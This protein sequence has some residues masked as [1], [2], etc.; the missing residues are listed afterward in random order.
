MIPA[1]SPRFPGGLGQHWQMI[2]WGRFRGPAVADPLQ[3]RRRAERLLRLVS[4]AVRIEPGF[5][6][7]VRLL[8][9]PEEA[10][11]ATEADVWQHPAVTST[12]IDGATLD[13][14]QA[15]LLR[16]AFA[17]DA[18]QDPQLHRRVLALLR[19]WRGHLPREIWFEEVQSLAPA[20]RRLLPDPSDVAL[21]QRFFLQLSQRARGVAPGTPGAGALSWFRRCERRLTP[22]AWTDPGVG[23][24]LHQ[25]SWSLHEQD[26]GFRPAAGFDPALV[27]ATWE[28][29]LALVQKGAVLCVTEL[30]EPT[31][32]PDGTAS[33]FGLLRS[34]NGL[35][36]LTVA[37]N[38]GR[39]DPNFWEI[40]RAPPWATDWGWDQYAAWV[41]FSINELAAGERVTQRM[42]WIQP[43]SFQMGSAT[44]EPGRWVD[45]GHRHEVGIREG[46]WLFETAC[47]QALWVAVMGKNPARF[48]GARR[49]V[50]RV[51][52]ND[53]Q[54]FI[55]ALNE[56]LPGLALSL[57]S[58][59]RWEYA[60]RAGSTTRYSFGD[61]EG[62]LGEHAWFNENAGGETHPVRE[63]K[64]NAWGLYDMQGNILEWVQDVWSHRYHGAPADG[65]AWESK[66][67][68]AVRVLRGGSWRSE[69]RSCRCAYRVGYQPDSN[70]DDL[71]FRC[72]RVQGREPGSAGSGASTLDTARPAERIRPGGHEIGTRNGSSSFDS[73][74]VLLRLDAGIE[75]SAPLPRAPVIHIRTDREQ[76]TLGGIA[77]PDWAR[78]IG[79]DRFGLWCEIAVETN[80]GEP[81]VQ[82]LRWIPP[83]RFRMGS[84]PDEP[85]HHPVEGPQHLVSLGSG[86]W[87]FDTPCTQSLW[88]ALMGDNPSAFRTPDRPVES[89]GWEEVKGFLDALNHR[90]GE[91]DGRF[92]LPSEA[93]WEYA[94]RAGTTTA[95]YS[96]SIEILGDANAPA[97]DPI[98]WYGGNSGVGFE[99]A[100]GLER[101]WLREMQYPE[102]RAGT[103]PV[104]GKRPNPWGLY[105]MLGN[106]WEWTQDVW[107]DSYEG[108]PSDGAARKRDDASAVRV[109]RGGSWSVNAR[110][111]RCAYRLKDDPD[112]RFNLL[113][114]RCAR[115][116]ES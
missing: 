7:A 104:K 22:S 72:A 47:T 77:K 66:D 29:R 12:S 102:G 73:G 61:D 83:G 5:L 94:C 14:A 24:A 85:G 59:A 6:R 115:T 15:A 23:A 35:V 38:A 98:A 45:E 37:A 57:P 101:T 79:R 46:F 42:R 32:L 110:H 39:K 33:P 71:G 44:Q 74:S 76:F 70:N 69:A 106:V 52:W 99:L 90:L 107:V 31:A 50:E 112:L 95:L 55:A 13:P 96:G 3:L 28:R 49:P 53:A 116:Q 20:T 114:F 63:R 111:C 1:P 75:A 40:G 43:G 58:E 4:P 26:A 87:L 19:L 54:C 18:E 10:D 84:P 113:G 60:C 27:P 36:Q 41:E 103:H 2:S 8:L 67:T 64:P 89:V 9:P 68:A 56:R 51:S 62:R 17:R 97:L 88:E 92:Q 82:R 109:V 65:S 93:Q 34:G 100:N 16:A 108:A 48:N 80:Q 81:V 25:L 11:A 86:Y 91:A 105:D 78:A 21:A 30:S